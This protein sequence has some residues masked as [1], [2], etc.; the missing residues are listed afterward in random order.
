MALTITVNISDADQV[1]LE[2]DLLDLDAWVQAAVAGK[3][4]NSRKCMVKQAGQVLKDDPAVDTMPA[5][6]D[7]LISALVARPEYKNRVDRDAA[8]VG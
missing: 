1:V 5:T 4:N 6:D 3:I 8:E 7:G 2:N